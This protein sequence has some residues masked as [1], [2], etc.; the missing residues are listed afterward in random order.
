MRLQ[1]FTKI[2]E[3]AHFFDG[4]TPKVSAASG[5]DADETF[6]LQGVEGFTHGRFADAELAGEEILGQARLF[7]EVA[8]EDVSLD[9]FICERSEISWRSQFFYNRHAEIDLPGS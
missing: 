8:F 1:R 4:Q 2:V 9:A 3:V 7:I 6:A 5:F